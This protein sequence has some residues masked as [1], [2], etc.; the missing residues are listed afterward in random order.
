MKYKKT[1]LFILLSLHS[2][3]LKIDTYL[4]IS[5]QQ[6]SCL[7]RLVNL[8]L[9]DLFY[10]FFYLTDHLIY[11]SSIYLACSF[12]ISCLISLALLCRMFQRYIHL[13]CTLH[14]CII[15]HKEK[16]FMQR[17]AQYLFFGAGCNMSHKDFLFFCSV[18]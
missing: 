3:L 6:S 8:D 17:L 1:L 10:F 9:K 4:F 14:F 13:R 7:N 12:Q 15:I 2:I 5:H 11:A 18:K 16:I